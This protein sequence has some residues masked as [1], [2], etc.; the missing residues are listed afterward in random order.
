MIHPKA[1]RESTRHGSGRAQ[2]ASGAENMCKAKS[3]GAAPR[4]R[5]GGGRCKPLAM[6][7]AAASPNGGADGGAGGGAG[8]GENGAVR[9]AVATDDL[10]VTLDV[11]DTVGLC[12]TLT[13]AE[14]CDVWLCVMPRHEMLAMENRRTASEAGE[15]IVRRSLLRE[16][17][18]A[19][20]LCNPEPSIFQESDRIGSGVIFNP[21]SYTVP[22]R[23]GVSRERRCRPDAH[24]YG[25]LVRSR[26]GDRGG[27][28]IP[29]NEFSSPV[30]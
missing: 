3:E 10:C 8:G 16:S 6:A 7:M 17:R 27:L 18:H 25:G 12:G 15:N 22:Q 19:T 29:T 13:L 21:T 26:F 1:G 5:G 30:S 9:L 2:R 11:P 24:S 20:A 14:V 28:N 23:D 4:A